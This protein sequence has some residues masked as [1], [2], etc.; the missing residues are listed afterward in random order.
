MRRNKSRDILDYFIK[1]SSRNLS[2]KRISDKFGISEKQVK[3]YIKQL[4]ESTS[5]N[6]IIVQIDSNKYCLCDDYESYMHLFEHTEYLPKDRIS[7]ILSKLL[8]SARP[9]DIFDLADE[10][11][12][13]RPTI[14][15]DLI[16]VRRNISAFNLDLLIK[17]DEV[18]LLG[19]EKDKRRLTSNLITSDYYAN[20]MSSDKTKYLNESYQID[21]LKQNLKKIFDEAHFTFNDYSLNNIAL[22]LVITIDRLKQQCEITDFLPSNLTTNMKKEAAE[23]TVSFLEENY[24]VVFSESEKQNL[25]MFLSCNLATVDYNFVNTKNISAYITDESEHLTQ[26]ILL[27]IKEYYALDDF[28][29]IFITR[30]MLHINNLLRRIN[31]NFSVHTPLA[32]EI[33]STYPLIYDIAVFVADIIY[34][35]TRY[36]INQDEISLIAL[37][38]GSFFESNQVNKNKLS[39]IYVYSN[40]HEFY[41]YNIEKIQKLFNDQLNIKFSISADNYESSD[42]KADIV[43]SEVQIPKKNIIFIS[44]FITESEISIIRS[45]T[46]VL[47]HKQKYDQFESD[48][49]Y[50]FGEKLFFTNLTGIDEFQVINK[51]LNKIEPLDYFMPSFPEEVIKREK[52]SSTCFKNGIAIPHSISQQVNKSFISFTCYDKGQTWN[53]ETVKLVILIGIAYHER[54]IFRSVFN[55]LINIFTNEAHVLSVSKCKTYDEIISTTK[56]ILEDM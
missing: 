29:E 51:I 32:K 9:L 20:F 26:L 25:A 3:N 14:D 55:Q 49:K 15:R 36:I 43:I 35:E 22:H 18:S 21:F 41:R 50:M 27:K 12:V 11:Y 6:I 1:H 28:D 30:F 7:N 31:T 10:L 37:H 4:N 46:D 19:T 42:I 38:I 33:M 47:I 52:L 2:I 53:D 39:T 34:T 44:P 13:S 8:L 17:N 24:D 5:P 40:Y 16:R 48:F 23:S 54:K 45:H 56:A